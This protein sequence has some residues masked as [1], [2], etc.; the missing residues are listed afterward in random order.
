ME[1]AKVQEELAAASFE[2]YSEDE[3]V[4]VTM[5][6]NQE[7]ISCDITDQVCVRVFR[8]PS[9]HLTLAH[10]AEHQQNQ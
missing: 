8:G 7:P 6:G 5:T 10:L 4:C 9:V 2:G 3:T 1:A